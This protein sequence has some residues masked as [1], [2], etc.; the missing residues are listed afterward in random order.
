MALVASRTVQLPCSSLRHCHDA[1]SK[2]RSGIWHLSHCACFL[3]VFVFKGADHSV[4]FGRPCADGS[5]DGAP[6]SNGC[7]HLTDYIPCG[8]KG[9]AKEVRDALDKID[10]ART[11]VEI[12]IRRQYARLHVGCRLA[13]R[14]HRNYRSARSRTGRGSHCRCQCNFGFSS[15]ATQIR[16]S[17]GVPVSR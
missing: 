9:E 3:Q 13:R 8:G 6:I 4:D 10:G 16:A 2:F 17:C 14:R 12:D 5:G 1:L 11:F 15:W 7:T